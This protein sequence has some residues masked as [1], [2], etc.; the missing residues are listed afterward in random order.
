MYTEERRRSRRRKTS[1]LYRIV[2]LAVVL[3]PAA[4]AVVQSVRLGKVHKETTEQTTQLEQLKQENAKLTEKLDKLGQSGMQTDPEGPEYQSLYPDFYAPQKLDASE[5]KEHTAYLTFD[6]G[7]S[8]NT[9]MILQTLKEENVKATFFVVGATG[10]QDLNRM[11]RIVQEGHT[12]GMHSYSHEYSNIYESVD[13]YL[14]DMYQLFQLIKNTTGVTPTCFRFPGGSLNAYNM[15]I[16]KEIMSEM[17]RR[18]FVPYD[19]NVSSGDATGEDYTPEQLT[20]NVLSGIDGCRRGIVLMHDSGQKVNTAR[21]VRDIIS[22]VRK[23]GFS[24][25][26]LTCQTKPVLFGYKE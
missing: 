22:G 17:L 6:D 3:V 23:M 24:L 13:A 16:Y 5:S 12:I 4:A 14:K 2:L 26:A 15:G 1:P 20:A 21:A 11:R 7:P 10:E 18:G 8:D 9:D 25:E 19:W